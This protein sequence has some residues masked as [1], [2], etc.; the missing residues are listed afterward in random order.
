[1][2]FSLAG[3][4][5]MFGFWAKLAVIRAAID[6]GMLW[7]AIVSVVFAVIGCFYYL[8]VVKVMFFDPPAEDVKIVPQ[9]DLQLR[10]V[11]SANALAMLV[12][13]LFWNPLLDMCIAAFAG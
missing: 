12:L 4:P 10:W 6:A 13:G 11:F 7:L 1:L 9:S 3:I 8:R 5:P 2:M